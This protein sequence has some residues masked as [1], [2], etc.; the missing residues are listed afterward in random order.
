MGGGGEKD[1]S[2]VGDDV[3]YNSFTGVVFSFCFEL[4]IIYIMNDITKSTHTII[5]HHI[6]ILRF[7]SSS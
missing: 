6:N 2:V 5:K 3:V 4:Y 7:L 1:T